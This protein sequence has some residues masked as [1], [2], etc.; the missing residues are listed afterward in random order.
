MSW[1]QNLLTL[2]ENTPL[3]NIDGEVIRIMAEIQD[4]PLL[5]LLGN[6]LKVGEL[7]K[8]ALE[9]QLSNRDNRQ[10]LLILQALARIPFHKL[11]LVKNA[12]GKAVGR[13]KKVATR[14][15][16]NLLKDMTEHVIEHW[17]K[18]YNTGSSRGSNDNND[19]ATS[20]SD[21]NS[22]VNNAA[23]NNDTQNFAVKSNIPYNSN[24]TKANSPVD[25]AISK[26]PPMFINNDGSTAAT[27]SSGP[28]LIPNRTAAYSTVS[29]TSSIDN[30]TKTPRV[31]LGETDLNGGLQRKRS[32]DDDQI[33]PAKRVRFKDDLTDVRLFDRHPSE[34][35]TM[36]S[37]EKENQSKSNSDERNETNAWHRP[38]KLKLSNP[39]IVL[40]GRVDSPEAIA[41]RNREATTLQA[42]Y[43]DD[44]RFLPM[45]PK[46]PDKDDNAVDNN[47]PAVPIIPLQDISAIPT[48][49][50][51]NTINVKDENSHHL[52]DKGPAAQMPALVDP[53]TDTLNTPTT[54][55]SDNANKAINEL[56][57]IEKIINSNP[58]LLA[59]FKELCHCA[60]QKQ[61]LTDIEAVQFIEQQAQ[62]EQ[63]ILQQVPS[64]DAED[65][66][67]A[68]K[69]DYS[70]RTGNN[71]K[72]YTCRTSTSSHDSSISSTS[73]RGSRGVS[74]RGHASKNARPM[75]HFYNTKR[76]CRRS[77]CP[78]RHVDPE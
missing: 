45:T 41:Q 51:N 15:D 46:E 62:P 47:S 57:Q 67:D 12:L 1:Q 36:L 59:T 42:A 11:I 2:I 71:Y 75:C 8:T 28:S 52:A 54:A 18:L 76:G 6:S 49:E 63:S 68:D 20:P 23:T 33:P 66:N 5:E 58:E 44:T 31:Q 34:W 25:L 73:T 69:G 55:L 3:N 19:V 9:Q 61:D 10:A 37:K 60:K 72:P 74:H 13:A 53:N 27:W 65:M 17:T 40:R 16:D 35:Q 39:N 38:P 77:P 56:D 24:S 43:L 70:S 4:P 78:F 32:K 14:N 64:N 30:V 48:I 21:S 29:H 50:S 26:E 22:S 7:L